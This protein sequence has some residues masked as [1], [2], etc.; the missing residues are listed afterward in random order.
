MPLRVMTIRSLTGGTGIARTRAH[1][2]RYLVLLLIPLAF[3]CAEA[4][5]DDLV[6]PDI[7]V[8]TDDDAKADQFD[9]PFT[10]VEDLQLRTTVG[11]TEE[12]RVIRSASSFKAAFGTSPPSWLDFDE[13]WLAVY[14]AGVKNTGGYAAEIRRLRLSDTGKSVK[15]TAALTSPGA[16]CFVTQALTK[17]FAV[18]RFPAQPGA[19]T[20]RFSKLAET[21]VCG[22][23]GAS[24][25]SAL[26][27]AADGMLFMSE[28]D[29][30]LTYVGWTGEGAPT[31]ANLSALLGVQ[32]GTLVEQRSFAQTMDHLGEAYDP[33]DPYIVEYAQTFR[34]LREV[35][36]ANLT[37]LTVIR[38]GEISIDVYFVG[39]S[40]C[41]DLVGL[42]TTSIET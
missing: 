37:D 29:Y 6:S 22:A 15:V 32:A 19:S 24:L 2:C 5:T 28:S 30:P 21:H 27:T 16:G 14:A 31:A 36:E 10:V 8:A 34:A 33:G 20:S 3:A 18:V 38:V 1:M 23:C 39:R 26:E 7:A 42:K 25:Q 35:M 17:P 11:R 9:L 12:G 40:S 4:P 13:E 41:G